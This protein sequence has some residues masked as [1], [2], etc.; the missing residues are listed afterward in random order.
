MKKPTVSLSRNGYSFVLQFSNMDDADYIF[1]EREVIE[2][3]DGLNSSKKQKEYHKTK[4][5]AKSHSSWSYTLG[6]TKNHP[7]DGYKR[8][9][10]FVNDSDS[11]GNPKQ[12]NLNKRVEGEP[13]WRI[14]ALPNSNGSMYVQAVCVKEGT[15][16]AE[17]D[18]GR[19]EFNYIYLYY[20]NY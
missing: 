18:Y 12:S 13:V 5:G 4:L 7:N 14:E 3:R 6:A 8:Y 17:K 10:P 16:A 19:V 2:H 11:N 1:I 20:G 9:Y 15:L